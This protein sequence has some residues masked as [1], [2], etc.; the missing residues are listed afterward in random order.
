MVQN[1]FLNQRNP[2]IIYTVYKILHFEIEIDKC[3]EKI[4][5]LK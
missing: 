5:G 4:K 2:Q 1:K 3:I